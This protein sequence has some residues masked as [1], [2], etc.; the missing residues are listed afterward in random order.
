MSQFEKRIAI[1]LNPTDATSIKAALVEY[2]QHLQDG[3]AFRF[4]GNLLFNIEFVHRDGRALTL[5][6]AGDKQALLER[7]IATCRPNEPDAYQSEPIL[8]AAAL[9]FAELMPELL[10]VAEAMVNF[11]RQRN[12]DGDLRLDDDN[13]FG[14][15]ALFMLALTDVNHSHYL[16]SFL[17][18][19]WNTESFS[20][21][22]ETLSHLV[23]E[24]GWQR[25]L[26]KAYLYCDSAHM[27]RF[28][29]Q[30]RDG[31]ETAPDL[32]S[33][34]LQH[35]DDYQWFKTQLLERLLARPV[36][37][38]PMESL[39]KAEVILG[40]FYS[41]G[42]WPV[43][44]AELTYY[45]EDDEWQDAVQ[46]LLIFGQTVEAEA[47]AIRDRIT[48]LQPGK[49]IEVIAQAWLHLESRY[50]AWPR[51]ESPEDEWNDDSDDE[52]EFTAAESQALKDLKFAIRPNWDRLT[53]KTNL[54]EIAA[55]LPT[56]ASRWLYE[57]WHYPLSSFVS[58]R[59]K[60]HALAEDETE[61]LVDWL[62]EYFIDESLE[63]IKEDYVDDDHE[64]CERL[65]AW[66]ALARIEENF[67]E[68]VAIARDVFYKDGGTRGDEISAKQPA[69]ALLWRHDGYQRGVLSLFWLLGCEQIQPE[70]NLAVLAR[71][72][73]QLLLALAPQ[74]VISR[75]CYYYGN[76]AHYAA[77][78]DESVEYQVYEQL[79]QLGVP[80]AHLQAFQLL[81]D[82]RVAG[83]RP[84]HQRFW[85]RYL[86]N[87]EHFATADEHATGMFARQQWLQRQALEQALPY[88]TE[89]AVLQFYA[90]TQLAY[91]DSELPIQALFEQALWR[92][93]H[94]SF[95]DVTAQQLYDKLLAYLHSGDGLEQ[96]T[97]QALK[98]PE[99]CGWKPYVQDNRIGPSDF[100]W[101]LP[102]EQAVRLVQFFCQQGE[103]G[104][105]FLLVP[106]AE[107]AFIQHLIRSG[108][109]TMAERW[110][111]A[112]VGHNRISDPDVGLPFLA[113]KDNWALNWLD[114]RGIDTAS[115]VYYAVTQGRD[116]EAF[117]GKLASEQR[118][119]KMDSHL[120]RKDL[121][122]LLQM[123]AT[124]QQQAESNS[125]IT[126]VPNSV[127]SR[128]LNDSS[129]AVKSLAKKLF[130][131]D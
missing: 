109:L 97:P 124:A 46:A 91:P 4:C 102:E 73:W 38:Y 30:G 61:E 88:C 103:R 13:Y 1:A 24:F 94:D 32:L 68:M 15:E 20:W 116:C 96:L 70:S 50:A 57:D 52:T 78:D 125:E 19:Y 34:L 87:I 42:E 121:A 51:D 17:T 131:K 64:Q 5:A 107:A 76:Y 48:E 111:H 69:Y 60:H 105:R 35:Q 75:V 29:Y 62:N 28:F 110:Q 89:T 122:K 108:E 9:N 55:N 21:A 43:A 31:D 6:D 7:A 90:D 127:F 114:E 115:L 2:L 112:E 118:L 16:A 71:R 33:Y 25:P 92:S 98:L 23:N 86:A 79:A 39:T 100:V 53:R 128:F 104:L 66:L 41:L 129:I 26:I 77:I 84:A 22:P 10:Q 56:P 82:Q 120:K 44:D 119:P 81:V 67:D 101:L 27:R 99:L 74:R 123:L 36:L 18:P 47:L 65:F 117:V 37:A 40:F 59:L 45:K 126:A 72:Q 49:P 8:F 11:A 80:E 113:A 54:D 14:L 93:L 58:Y 12:D 3:S 106:P 85:Q 95:A 83:Y 130:T 63:S